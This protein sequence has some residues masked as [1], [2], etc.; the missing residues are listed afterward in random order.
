M[1]SSIINALTGMQAMH[2][3]VDTIANNIANAATDGFKSRETQ[4]TTLLTREI[5]NQPNPAFEQ[6]RLTPYNVRPGVGVKDTAQQIDF[7]QGTLKQTDVPTDLALEGSGFFRVQRAGETQPS[8]TRDGNFKLMPAAGAAGQVELVTATGDP[9]MSAA[10][11]PIRIAAPYTDLKIVADG[12]ITYKDSIGRQRNGPKIGVYTI[13]N[14]NILENTGSNYYRIPAT[15]PPQNGALLVNG[16][17]ARTMPAGIA[18]HQGA[19]EMSNVDLQKEMTSLIEA[20][21]ALQF[22][23]RAL[24]Y[25][26]QM[27]SV[28][29]QI[30]KG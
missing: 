4:F 9:V 13:Q 19:L 23:S 3:K 15:V 6:G 27:M 28:T 22:N 2:A 5:N 25:S 21:R 7:T 14:P 1:N 17:A 20:Q 26:D 16:G 18:V 29:N 10:G 30:Y 8:Y 24:T 11:Q 12:Q